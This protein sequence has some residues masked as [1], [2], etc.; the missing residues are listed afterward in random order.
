MQARA[1]SWIAGVSTASMGI[2][3][4]A[5]SVPTLLGRIPPNS[6]YGFRTSKT[7]SNPNTWYAANVFASKVTIGIGVVMFLLG[8]LQVYLAYRRVLSQRDV[9]LLWAL[10]ELGPL[11]VLV[12]ILLIYNLKLRG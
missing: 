8:G 6:L 12:V 9:G 11:C 1:F 4:I 7:L 5:L 2:L 10:S 3:L